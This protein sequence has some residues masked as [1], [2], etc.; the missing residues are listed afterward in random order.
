MI[1]QDKERKAKVKYILKHYKP[2]TVTSDIINKIHKLYPKT[3]Y[4]NYITPK[5]IYENMLLCTVTLDLKQQHILGVCLK[6]Y[7][8]YNG[9]IEKVLLFNPYKNLFWYIKPTKYYLFRAERS[10]EINKKE[11]Y[12]SYLDAILKK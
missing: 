3:R 9:D 8:D 12:R 6:I 11:I 4:Y 10:K 1:N 2:K 5:D 7:N